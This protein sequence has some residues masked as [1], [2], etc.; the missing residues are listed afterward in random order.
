MHAMITEKGYPYAFDASAC[1][2]CGGQCCTGE[3]GNIFV[4]AEE[5]RAMAAQLQLDEGAF[6]RTYL[7][8]RGYKLSLK[9]RRIGESY[10][11]IF[12]DRDSQGCGIY[13]ARPQQCR[14]FPFWDYYK[15]RVS[16]LKQECPGV[17]DV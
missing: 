8:K 5:I 9:E 4:S 13:A 15:Q 17:I 3:S 11:C 7:E 12:F 10:D 2:G 1:A 16:L 6:R 14:T